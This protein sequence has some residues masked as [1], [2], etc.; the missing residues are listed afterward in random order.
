MNPSQLNNLEIMNKNN[1]KLSESLLYG[2]M[3]EFLVE[4]EK[5]PAAQ[6]ECEKDKRAKAIEAACSKLYHAHTVF[7]PSVNDYGNSI[8]LI[9]NDMPVK[10]MIDEA[11]NFCFHLDNFYTEIK[12]ANSVQELQQYYKN[13]TLKP[14]LILDSLITDLKLLSD[15]YEFDID[16]KTVVMA[17]NT[18]KNGL[19]MRK[20]M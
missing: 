12:K 18:E 13:F 11:V 4:V 16:V 19:L 15:R 10:Y 9:D 14:K 5:Y 1:G 6:I 7:T 17:Y 8:I 20:K 2:I 3:S